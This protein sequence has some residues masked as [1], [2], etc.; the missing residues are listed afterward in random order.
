MSL[1]ESIA[2][3]AVGYVVAIGTQMAVFPLFGLNVSV[4]SNLLIGAIFTFISIV[5]SYA[6]RRVFNRIGEKS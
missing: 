6:M 4:A 2:N 3:V 1:I 5:R